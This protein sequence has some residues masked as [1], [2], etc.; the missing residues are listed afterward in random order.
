MPKITMA[1]RAVTPDICLISLSSDGG[2]SRIL[3]AVDHYWWHME[4]IRISEVLL[5]L[6]L[7]E[8]DLPM[9]VHVELMMPKLSKQW[10]TC[11]ST[12]LHVYSSWSNTSVR[13]LNH[14]GTI[15]ISSFLSQLTEVVWR[16]PLTFTEISEWCRWGL[17][18]SLLNTLWLSKH[19]SC[20][21]ATD[22]IKEV[23]VATVKSFI[24]LWTTEAV[25]FAFCPALIFWDANIS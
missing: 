16:T 24:G 10:V 1:E 17:L 14:Q 9:W 25:S 22:R 12:W 3:T 2:V 4:H 19:M 23:D 6:L 5:D 8:C 11:R 15:D 13:T 20:L 18:L 21:R 7:L